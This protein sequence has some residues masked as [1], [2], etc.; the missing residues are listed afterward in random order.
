MILTVQVQVHGDRGSDMKNSNA[1]FV[2]VE[3]VEYGSICNC[4]NRWSQTLV[5]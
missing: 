4:A 5:I 1:I 3:F 2:K